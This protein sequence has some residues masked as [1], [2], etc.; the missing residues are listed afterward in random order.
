[1]SNPAILKEDETAMQTLG[2]GRNMVKSLQ[3]WAESSGIIQSDGQRGHASG[4][5]GDL[6]LGKKGLDQHLESL[7]SL[8]LIHWQLSTRANIAAWNLVFGEA[9]LMRFERSRLIG[10]LGDRGA[11]LARPLASSTLEQHASI[12]INSYLPSSRSGD[13][14]S[15]CPLQDLGVLK[16]SKTED[17]RTIYSTD[18][19]SPVGLSYR[20]F[21]I[22]LIDY[23]TRNSNGSWTVDLHS[24][25]KGEF[26]PGVVFR[27]DE[28]QLREFLQACV[29]SVLL[30][31]LRFID[32]AD[33]QSLVLE[34]KELNREFRSWAPIKVQEHA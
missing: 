5:L 7:E 22:A 19:G 17:G 1:L 23:M 20:A 18:V 34:P 2:I 24:V 11:E 4:P 13:D 14:T 15:W 8:W 16:A 30:G 33:T 29:D 9:K 25:L 26:S 32:T 31:A 28:Y 10:A 12:L 3:F 21:A 6:L 27:L